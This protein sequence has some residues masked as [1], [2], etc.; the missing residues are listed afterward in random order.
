MRC[1]KHPG[2]IFI[3]LFL[4]IAHFFLALCAV[5]SFVPGWRY[6]FDPVNLLSLIWP[7][8]W[9]TTGIAFVMWSGLWDKLRDPPVENGS[10]V[11]EVSVENGSDCEQ[12]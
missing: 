2:F 5:A 8:I 9:V 10:D 12:V 4:G 6:L 3:W 11:P 1:S 7:S